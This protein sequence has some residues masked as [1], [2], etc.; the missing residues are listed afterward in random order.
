VDREL[1][2]ELA[3]Y[4]DAV[5][6]QIADGSS[7]DER[8]G[9]ATLGIPPEGRPRR[10]LGINHDL[11]GR[12]YRAVAS[13]FAITALGRSHQIGAA[14]TIFIVMHAVLWR[15][16]RL[17]S[18]RRHRPNRWCSNVALAAKS[19]AASKDRHRRQ[20]WTHFSRLWTRA[21]CGGKRF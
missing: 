1:D 5:V 14:V 11:A 4:L 10:G 12:S 7:R 9:P 3:H 15:P 17:Q 20:W 18:A 2:D 16:L 8:R 6:D 19:R 21:R 13:G